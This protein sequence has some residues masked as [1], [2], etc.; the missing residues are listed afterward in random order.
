LSPNKIKKIYEEWLVE[1]AKSVFK[2][3]VAEYSK[4]LG[5]K[6]KGITIKHLKNRW[7][8]MTKQS[9]IKLNVNLLKGS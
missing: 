7:G 2:H 4:K 9:S 3:K 8:S 6:V 5:V 1:K